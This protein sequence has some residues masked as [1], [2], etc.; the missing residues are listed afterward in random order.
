MCYLDVPSI[1]KLNDMN[2]M[3]LMDCKIPYNPNLLWWKTFTVAMSCQNSWENFC[4]CV[5][6][7]I[8]SYIALWNFCWKTFTLTT[9]SVKTTIVFH[10]GQFVLYGMPISLSYY[11]SFFFLFHVS[12]A[13]TEQALSLETIK[14]SLK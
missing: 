7:A 13:F 14:Q 12:T 8:T 3:I 10:C 9:W 4:G 11:L 5:I 2:F 1:I 6:H